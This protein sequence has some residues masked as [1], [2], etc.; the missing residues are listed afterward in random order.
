MAQLNGSKGWIAAIIAAVAITWTISWATAP[1]NCRELR[2]RV[3]ELEKKDAADQVTL[4][5]I[6]AEI[7]KINAKLDKALER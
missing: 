6:Q 4:R 3:V 7:E 1:G 5:S 2:P